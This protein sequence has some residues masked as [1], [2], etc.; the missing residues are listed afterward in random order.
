MDGDNETLES[1]DCACLTRVISLYVAK[2]SRVERQIGI[3]E[4]TVCQSSNHLAKVERWQKVGHV[5][6]NQSGSCRHW[7][8]PCR[9]GRSRV[10]RR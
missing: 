1:I 6:W 2:M 9:L 10:I 7:M 8:V 5:P 4:A 3:V